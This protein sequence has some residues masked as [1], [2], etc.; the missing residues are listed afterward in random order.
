MQMTERKPIIEFK[1]VSKRYHSSHGMVTALNDINFVIYPGEIFGVI[2]RSG[3]GKSSLLRCINLLEHPTSG[4][5]IVNNHD[6][7]T[8]SAVELHNARRN[9]GMI[10]QQFNLLSRKTVWQ[11]IALPLQIM[12]MPTAKIKTRVHEL[13]HLVGLSERA[14]HYPAQLSGGQKQRA[15]IARALATHPQILLC[16]EATSA[17]DPHSTQS[18][19]QL[20][21]DINKQLGITIVL[22]T[23]E[24]DVV[25]SICHRVALLENGNILQIKPVTA[26]FSQIIDPEHPDH[27]TVM[28]YIGESDWDDRLLSICRHEKMSG[29][30]LRIRFHGESAAQPLIAHLIK[31]FG[32]EINILQAN[33]E[34]VG[35]ELVGTM[36]VQAG[37]HPHIDAGLAFL[38]AKG[39]MVEE[40]AHVS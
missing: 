25:K 24:V 30:L 3:A 22:I 31:E 37:S 15:A 36:I 34:F 23:H 26:F 12:G 29:L 21:Q 4:Q 18:I 32:L 38:R 16:D 7:M 39:V 10:F 40:L 5:V 9:I 11:N 1:H 6:Q 28:S 13:L 14:K 35:E 17:L 20:L 2:G 27:N 8:L 19:L 33:L